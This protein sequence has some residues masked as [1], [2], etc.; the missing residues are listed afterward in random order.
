VPAYDG[1]SWVFVAIPPEGVAKVG[2]AAIVT[3][4]PG[5]EVKVGGEAVG[6]TPL[7]Y[8]G[9]PDTALELEVSTADVSARS[10]AKLA[11]EGVTVT[12]PLE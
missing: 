6:K 8:L 5:A 9:A 10:S 1:P 2:W 12:V 3:D 7:V 11:A 4:P